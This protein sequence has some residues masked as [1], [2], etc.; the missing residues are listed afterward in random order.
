MI[1]KVID[2]VTLEVVADP[3]HDGRYAGCY[4]AWP[5]SVRRDVLHHFVLPF[6]VYP[7]RRRP[8]TPAA[9]HPLRRVQ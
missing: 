8:G 6:D 7:S 3:E 5:N 1:V 2:D 4:I 9:Q